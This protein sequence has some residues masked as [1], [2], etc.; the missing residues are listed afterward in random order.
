MFSVYMQ[1]VNFKIF[2]IFNLFYL[3]SLS[4]PTFAQE[5]PP[6]EFVE[7]CISMVMSAT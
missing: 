3:L 4:D 7:L 6:S 5:I 2:K 1:E